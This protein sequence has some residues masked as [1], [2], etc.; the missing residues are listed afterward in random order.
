M[1]T[2]KLIITYLKNIPVTVLFLLQGRGKANIKIPLEQAMK[3]LKGRISIA[4]L[5]L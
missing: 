2:D 1:C 4:L 3:A 5:I